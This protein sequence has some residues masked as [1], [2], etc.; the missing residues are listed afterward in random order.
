MG[1]SKF[2]ADLELEWKRT[3]SDRIF[4]KL[5]PHYHLV[6]TGY[7]YKHYGAQFTKDE[8]DDLI[9]TLFE[10]F[11]KHKE[12][13]LTN[14]KNIKVTTWL[15]TVA[16]TIALDALTNKRKQYDK[17]PN[18]GD[19]NDI[20]TKIE[21]NYISCSLI[22]KDLQDKIED[23]DVISK[24]YETFTKEINNLPN[25][26]GLI[27][28]AKHLDNKTYKEIE[29]LFPGYDHVKIRTAIWK[30]KLIL[31]QNL[32]KDYEEMLELLQF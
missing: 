11:L 13:I 29:T 21:N 18:Y 6:V 32:K 23:E 4:N 27:F 25:E 20:L 3:G 8:I 5:Y 1:Y 7:F 31:I 14:F 22:D 17:S 10:R 24:F 9:S 19:F 26:L 28:K 12:N 2:N 30:A 15:I 16:R